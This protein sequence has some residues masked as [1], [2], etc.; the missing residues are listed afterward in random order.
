M[1]RKL[2]RDSSAILVSQIVSFITSLAMGV[3]IARVLG[4]EGKGTL[5]LLTLVPMMIAGFATMG[6]DV[7]NVYFIGKKKY[8]IQSI[9]SNSIFIALCIS[10]IILLI[11][12]LLIPK[13][14]S[15]LKVDVAYW[16]KLVTYFFI[17]LYLL[18]TYFSSF[19][20]GLQ[21]III[22][23]VID[24]IRAVL[25]LVLIIVFLFLLH[26]NGLYS[27]V[28]IN[29]LIVFLTVCLSGLSLRN[30]I[31]FKPIYNREVFK[32]T[33]S[34]GVKAYVG[35]IAHYF[36][37][38]LDFFFVA[39]FLSPKEVGFY[40]VAVSM[41]ELIWYVPVAISTVLVPAIAGSSKETSKILAY[42]TF[43]KMLIPFIIMS[44][45]LLCSG[46]F[47]IRF[48]YGAQFLPA[49]MPLVLLLPGVFLMAASG[50]FEDYIA[51]R[52][53]IEYNSL[54]AIY[55]FAVTIVLDILLIPKLGI[56]G[57][58][59]ASSCAYSITT[60]I[61]IYYYLKF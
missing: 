6:I 28:I 49:F 17:P 57:A 3:V 47:L 22:R 18:G 16:L 42:N 48:L 51:G 21:K 59:I 25:L 2:I 60:L 27:V 56:S 5:K 54:T 44:L 13:F 43:R 46:K 30:I 35:S 41:A 31:N 11:Y 23:S 52:G 14:F 19:L 37:I 20:V 50:P 53:K 7:A 61:S 39:F 15:L 38:R 12:P 24:I 29:I 40:S 10:L 8:D 33:T 32:T 34:Y 58:A 4:P 1:Y 26:F 45:I 9:V 36:N 55:S